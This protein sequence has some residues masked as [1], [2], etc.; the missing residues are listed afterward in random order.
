ML[1]ITERCY[2]GPE[3]YHKRYLHKVPLHVIPD[4]VFEV[5]PLSPFFL[6]TI[7]CLLSDNVQ[8][9]TCI[10]VPLSCIKISSLLS[11]S[12]SSSSQGDSGLP[13]L[14]GHMSVE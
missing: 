11:L 2:E 14:H 3:W 7:D 1:E 9:I 13:P 4:D 5:T 12:L 6:Y 10:N 8:P